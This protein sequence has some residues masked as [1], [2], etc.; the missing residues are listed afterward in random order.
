MKF[1]TINTLFH[2]PTSRWPWFLIGHSALV[3]ELIAL[4]FQ[5]GMHLE[6]CIMCVYQRAAVMAIFLFSIPALLIPRSP[7]FRFISIVPMCVVSLW[8][9][10]IAIEHVQMQSPDNFLLLMTCDIIP[11]FPSWFAIHQWFPAVFEATGSCGEIDWSLLSLS[12]P[13]WMV[14]VFCSYSLLFVWMML[15]EVLNRSRRL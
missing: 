6:P 14:I 11:N 12:M 10:S 7:F 15:V 2:W 3:L 9:F 8:G 13:E 1:E 4:Y 5:Y